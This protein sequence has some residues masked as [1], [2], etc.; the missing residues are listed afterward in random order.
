LSKKAVGIIRVSRV[1]GRDKKNGGEAFHSP[2]VQRERIED[3]CARHMREGWR[4]AAVLD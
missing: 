1:G 2:E 4:L 3:F